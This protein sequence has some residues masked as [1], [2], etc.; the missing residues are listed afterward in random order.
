M[1]AIRAYTLTEAKSRL[2]LWKK[3][4]EE[5]AY[6][7]AKEYTI[8]NRTYKAID[9]DEVR[10]QIQ[11]YSDIVEAYED[12]SVKKTRVARVIFRDL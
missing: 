3:C 7:T 8:G 11:Y 2:E 10:K 1:A 4:E 5:L 6:G 9:L 12:D